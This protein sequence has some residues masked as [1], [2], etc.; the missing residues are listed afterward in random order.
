[1]DYF[2]FFEKWKALIP[3]AHWIDFKCDIINLKDHYYKDGQKDM[4]SRYR[5]PDTTGQ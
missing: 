5:F 1:M 2:K 4:D 3:E